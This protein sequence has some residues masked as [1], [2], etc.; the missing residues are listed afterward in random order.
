MKFTAPFFLVAASMLLLFACKKDNDV[1]I[2]ENCIVVEPDTSQA[3]DSTPILTISGS[4][5]TINLTSPGISPTSGLTISVG[6][7]GSLLSETLDPATQSFSWVLDNL[8]PGTYPVLIRQT[9]YVPGSPFPGFLFTVNGSS[10]GTVG[11]VA[12]MANLDTNTNEV[13]Y[14]FNLQVNP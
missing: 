3:E 14:S 11:P 6:D 10:S 7:G 2:C 4:Q 12:P 1:N 13:E 5:A 8:S 9:N